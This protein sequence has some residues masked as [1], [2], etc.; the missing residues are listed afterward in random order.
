MHLD[1]TTLALQLV[2]FLVLVWLLRR[3]L[4]RPVLAA[5]DK[6]DADLTQRR[7]QAETLAAE[8]AATRSAVEAERQSLAKQAAELR[9]T[10]QA[11]AEAERRRLLDAA[12]Q[13]ADALRAAAASQLAA[14]RQQAET[15]LTKQAADLATAMAGRLLADARPDLADRVLTDAL[16]QQLATLPAAEKSSLLAGPGGITLT[17]ARPLPADLQSALITALGPNIAISWTVDPAVIAG[18]ELSAPH[19]LI[20]QSW[21]AALAGARERLGS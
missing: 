15:D 2:N 13:S 3:F 17:S 9:A 5:I 20:H 4:F 16:C 19:H 12:R 14:E 18:V 6:R 10:A 21:R 11:E 7:A 8:V 1:P